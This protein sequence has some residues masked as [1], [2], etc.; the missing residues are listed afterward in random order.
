MTCFLGTGGPM[1]HWLASCT[2]RAY[3]ASQAQVQSMG[4]GSTPCPIDMCQ[5]GMGLP[6]CP[7]DM[8]QWGMG[9]QARAPLT[10][11]IWNTSQSGTL[12]R[13]E[14]CCTS[15]RNGRTLGFF[16]VARTPSYR[17]RNPVAPAAGG[18]QVWWPPLPEGVSP[19]MLN[20]CVMVM[21]SSW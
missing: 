15:L 17:K 2:L 21:L 7:N 14:E 1:P 19:V 8:C 6:P 4:H 9:Q 10:H 20:C 13:I 3:H 12:H 18:T 16:F 11:V 5:W